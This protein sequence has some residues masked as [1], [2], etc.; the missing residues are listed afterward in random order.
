MSTLIF[1]LNCG[2]VL[3]TAA[4]AVLGARGVRE[5]LAYFLV[6][7]LALVGVFIFVGAPVVAVAQLLF[8]A[9]L[10]LIYF[11]AIESVDE[12]ARASSPTSDPHS[13]NWL[14][15]L[16]GVAGACLMASLLVEVAPSKVS[17]DG[18]EQVARVTEARGAFEAIGIEVIVGSGLALLGVGLVLVAS[19]V[20]AGFLASKERG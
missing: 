11:F 10:G 3:L 7:M 14:A 12:S 13:W 1:Y 8:C 9:G 2:L 20:G 17:S 15:I 4:I 19:A 5:S 6:S 18:L 16:L